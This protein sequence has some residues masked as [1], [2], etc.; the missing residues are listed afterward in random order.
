MISLHLPLLLGWG[1]TVIE[2]RWHRPYI[3]VKKDPLLTCLL[4]FCAS[5]FD[6]KVDPM[7]ILQTL[8]TCGTCPPEQTCSTRTEMKMEKCGSSWDDLCLLGFEMV[9]VKT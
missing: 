7:L 3:L 9:C 2:S 6:L 5:C 4:V 1:G 8:N